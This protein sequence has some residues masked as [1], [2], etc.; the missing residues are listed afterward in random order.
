MQTSSNF[1]RHW[2]HACNSK[3]S[4]WLP[5]GTPLSCSL[6]VE[7]PRTFVNTPSSREREKKSGCFETTTKAKWRSECATSSAPTIRLE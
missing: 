3:K 1:S 4:F 5:P 6:V 2:A 7:N